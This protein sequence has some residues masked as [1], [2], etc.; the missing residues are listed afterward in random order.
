MYHFTHTFSK[1]TSQEDATRPPRVYSVKNKT[2]Q[3]NSCVL[4]QSCCCCCLLLL[5]EC[6]WYTQDHMLATFCFI[7]LPMA[8]TCFCWLAKP[9]STNPHSR[10]KGFGQIL[11]DSELWENPHTNSKWA[12]KFD[13][14]LDLCVSSLRRGHANLLCIVPIL[15]DDPRRESSRKAFLAT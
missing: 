11:C 13:T 5:Q 3:H 2:Q 6:A 1:Q 14:L 9:C 7:S 10:D 12:K 8:G 4:V 15:S